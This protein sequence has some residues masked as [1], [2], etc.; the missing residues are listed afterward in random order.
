MGEKLRCH[1]VS[2]RVKVSLTWASV[3]IANRELHTHIDNKSSIVCYDSAHLFPPDGATF[4][5]SANMI[6]IIIILYALGT[7]FPE[8]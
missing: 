6:R 5:Q 8:G 3:V 4:T 1:L 2:N 7:L